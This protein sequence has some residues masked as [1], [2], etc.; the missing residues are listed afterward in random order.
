MFSSW[1]LALTSLIKKKCIKYSGSVVK[2]ISFNVRQ[3]FINCGKGYIFSNILHLHLH[4]TAL[5]SQSMVFWNLALIP[6][7]WEPTSCCHLSS[8]PHQNIE[9]RQSCLEKQ[10]TLELKW[11]THFVKLGTTSSEL[12]PE[13]PFSEFQ[14]WA[15]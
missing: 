9:G 3:I 4:M 8:N 7:S 2:L 14:L 15:F 5:R 10:S 13:F 12:G 1:K 6:D 11:I